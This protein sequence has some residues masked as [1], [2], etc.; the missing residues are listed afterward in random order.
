MT[1]DPS[2]VINPV[3]LAF[4]AEKLHD[5]RTWRHVSRV[6]CWMKDHDLKATFFVY[7]FRAQ[8]AGK[9]ITDRLATIASL[10]H[11]IGQHTHFY[12]GTKIEK[13]K[14]DDLSENNIMYCL[15]RDFQT[16][17]RM[18]FAPKA[19]TAGAWFVTPKVYD[20]LIGLGFSYDCSAQ[21]PK[22][23]SRC[24]SPYNSL[25]PVSFEQAGTCS[26]FADNV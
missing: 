3:A 1:Y 6:A 18:G 15:D 20:T 25:T 14:T 12:A 24:H 4:H 19:F 22:P 16:L 10:G 5:D 26:V 11:H 2:D 21:F 8:I 17:Q 13:D 23:N 9:D 7:P